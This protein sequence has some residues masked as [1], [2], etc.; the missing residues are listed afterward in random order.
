MN[1]VAAETISEDRPTTAPERQKA[2]AASA[3]PD[4]RER[5]ILCARIAAD[6][7]GRDVQVLDLT[8]IVEW[9]DYLVI[10]TGSSRRQ[11]V[12]AADEIDRVMAELGDKKYGVEGY[13]QGGWV[14]LDYGDVLIHLFDDEKR[15]YYQ[16]ETLW[17]DA[18]R[19]P[20][21]RP[22]DETAAESEPA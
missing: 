18:P 20:W 7:R 13:E 19:V 15:E 16:L 12:A 2:A 10:A 9:V 8:K 17:D 22:V 11:I 21:E 1:A 6:Y 4:G 3:K 5:A 14:V